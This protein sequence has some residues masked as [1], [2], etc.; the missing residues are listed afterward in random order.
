[1]QTSDLLNSLSTTIVG[2]ASTTDTSTSDQIKSLQALYYTKDPTICACLATKPT[3]LTTTK[4]QPEPFSATDLVGRILTDPEFASSAFK[5][6]IGLIAGAFFL[7]TVI[8]IIAC[9]ASHSPNPV[10]LER[11]DVDFYNQKKFHAEKRALEIKIEGEGMVKT[12]S[13]EF[14]IFHDNSRSLI[15]MSI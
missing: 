4:T 1:M 6:L 13:E 2:F 12:R 7:I 9:V 15:G 5:W 11:K 10:F 8:F 3:V 14:S